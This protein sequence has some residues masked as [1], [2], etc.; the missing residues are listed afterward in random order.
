MLLRTS[1]PNRTACC[2]VGVEAIRDLLHVV[3]VV[4]V[5][6]VFVVDFVVVGFVIFDV[7]FVLCRVEN[8]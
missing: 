8:V 4:V 3:V 5:V 2:I 1:C 6:V 7:V